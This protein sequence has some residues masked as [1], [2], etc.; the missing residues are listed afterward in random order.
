[1]VPEVP[2]MPT[3]N[4]KGRLAITHFFTRTF[5]KKLFPCCHRVA[6]KRPK[7][8]AVCSEEPTTDYFDTKTWATKEALK[9]AA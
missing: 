4:R 8:G 3:I 9:I 5:M 2:V 7:K 1:M 6:R